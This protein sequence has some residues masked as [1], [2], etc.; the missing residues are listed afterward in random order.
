M[1]YLIDHEPIGRGWISSRI[2]G[3]KE[4]PIVEML[5]WSDNDSS[6]SQHQY[7]T[8]EESARE[9]YTEY[10]K[11]AE[12]SSSPLERSELSRAMDIGS[13]EEFGELLASGTVRGKR[14]LAS[15]SL[16]ATAYGRIADALPHSSGGG[17]SFLDCA[18]VLCAAQPREQEKVK[19]ITNSIDAM[20]YEVATETLV[21]VVDKLPPTKALMARIS[22]LRAL[23]R[24]ARFGLPWLPMKSAQEGSAILGG[25][26][27]FGT[28]LERAGRTWNA[29][30]QSKVRCD[31]S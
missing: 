24:R 20:V 11:V 5:P 27:G 10:T 6:S 22:M 15:D 14:E 18:M 19:G 17:C 26:C 23:N 31:L 7:D 30:A 4:E 16:I 21:H 25:L 9:W 12:S 2:R 13:V 29:A 28:S 1:R 3:G 8:P